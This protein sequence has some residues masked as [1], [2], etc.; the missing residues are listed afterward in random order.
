MWADNLLTRRKE[1][2]LP[3]A[4]CAMKEGVSERA[5]VFV[6]ARDSRPSSVA[7]AAV[8]RAGMGFAAVVSDAAGDVVGGRVYVFGG[9]GPAAADGFGDLYRCGPDCPRP[10]LSRAV[11]VS[12]GQRSESTLRMA[13]A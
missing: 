2:A 12:S 6:G 3:G 4:A 9:A 1:L 8:A 10:P 13:Q 11:R 5:R 7:V